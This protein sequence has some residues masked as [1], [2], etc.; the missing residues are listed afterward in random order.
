MYLVGRCMRVCDE[1]QGVTNLSQHRRGFHIHV[2]PAHE[3][4]MMSSVC[5]QCGPFANVR[6]TAAVLGHNSTEDVFRALENPE[7]H[8]IVR[9]APSIRAAVGEGF[10]YKPATPVT[11]KMVSALRL[12]GFNKIFDTNLGADLTIVEE[13]YE[14]VR[15]LE[16]NDRLPLITSCAPGWIK[17]LEHFYPELIPLHPHAVLR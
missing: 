7:L 10:G 3:R 11:G 16:K 9:T 17:F 5:V 8:V 15:R 2:A 14:F 6:P 1:V 12:M 13:A 4:D